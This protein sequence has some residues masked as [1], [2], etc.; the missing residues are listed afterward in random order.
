MIQKN[1]NWIITTTDEH[2]VSITQG[3]SN[4]TKK[5]FLYLWIITNYPLKTFALSR[6]ANRLYAIFNFDRFSA[7]RTAN[8]QY[9]EHIRL[10]VMQPS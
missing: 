5:I 10:R 9:I 3:V 6:K 1:A 7:V 8:E 2:G 4:I